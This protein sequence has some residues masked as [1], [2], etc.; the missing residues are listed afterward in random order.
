MGGRRPNLVLSMRRGVAY[1]DVSTE[2]YPTAV[3]AV[4]ARDLHLV[5]DGGPRWVAA[6]CKKNSDRLYAVRT[7]G[8]RK[9]KRQMLHRVILGLSSPKVQGD[10]RNGEGLDNRRKNLR[11][12]SHAENCRNGARRR[13]GTS[14][15]R[16]VSWDKERQKWIGSIRRPDGNGRKHLGRFDKERDAALAYD[17][18][19]ARR[20]G[21]FARLNFPKVKHG[22]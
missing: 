4:E 22:K 13:N 2:K 18:E 9:G 7:V 12:A 3:T 1:V 20:Y 10:H 17:K 6:K 16:G 8:G 15:F 14:K 21:E 11:R 19:A 5:L